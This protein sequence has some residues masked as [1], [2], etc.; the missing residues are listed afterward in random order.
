MRKSG[1]SFTDDLHRQ[2]LR[3]LIKNAILRLENV[4][5]A[6]LAG[7]AYFL[8]PRPFPFWQP[9]FWLVGGAVAE[10]VMFV[11]TITDPAEGERAVARLFREEFNP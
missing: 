9:W 7:G 11:V 8:T 1:N 2:A 6:L 10:V 5:V 3:A 4:V